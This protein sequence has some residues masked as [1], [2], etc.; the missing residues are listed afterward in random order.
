MSPRE[1]SRRGFRSGWTLVNGF[2]TPLALVPPF[3]ADADFGGYK[4]V[5]WR[6]KVRSDKNQSVVSA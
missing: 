6:L 3:A 4:M 2:A 1:K 5:T